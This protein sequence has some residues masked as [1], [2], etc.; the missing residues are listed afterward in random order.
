M[1]KINEKVSEGKLKK[2]ENEGKLVNKK[3]AGR[4]KKIGKWRKLMKK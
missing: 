2:K 4:L 1:K 3:I